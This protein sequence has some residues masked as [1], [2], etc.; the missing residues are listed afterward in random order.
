MSPHQNLLAALY[1][2]IEAIKRN[3]LYIKNIISNYA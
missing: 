2:R 3:K 1:I